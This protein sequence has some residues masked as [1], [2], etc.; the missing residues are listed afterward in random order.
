MWYNTKC[1]TKIFFTEILPQCIQTEKT[2]KD[3]IIYVRQFKNS[4]LAIILIEW[5]GGKS[6]VA[7]NF[8][9]KMFGIRDFYH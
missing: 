2:K 5:N 3:G 7:A 1:Q 4:K 6:I 8:N 9:E